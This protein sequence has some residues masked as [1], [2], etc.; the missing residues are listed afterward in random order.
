MNIERT[1]H[2]HAHGHLLAISIAIA[3]YFYLQRLPQTVRRTAKRRKR[4]KSRMRPATMK[5][6]SIKFLFSLRRKETIRWNECERRRQSEKQEAKWWH[7]NSEKCYKFCFE[8]NESIEIVSKTPPDRLSV[9]ENG[10]RM[11]KGKSRLCEDSF[12]RV[13]TVRGKL[14]CDSRPRTWNQFY[15]DS[16]IITILLYRID[17]DG[18]VRMAFGQWQF[19]WIGCAQWPNGEYEIQ[20]TIYSIT[21]CS[22]EDKN[23]NQYWVLTVKTEREKKLTDVFA[24]YFRTN[25]KIFI[26]NGLCV[27]VCSRIYCCRNTLD[28]IF[29]TI[30]S[31]NGVQRT[32]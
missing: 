19:Q 31:I 21:F 13:E 7:R 30:K 11:W 1:A 25:S 27:C 18:Y 32:S 29:G 2:T 4:R 8:L 3:Y 14:G 23:N 17:D 6:F 15:F 5:S 24:T 10:M 28:W 16:I 9:I 22:I 12:D 20:Y 26:H